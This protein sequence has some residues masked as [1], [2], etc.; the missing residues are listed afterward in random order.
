MGAMGANRLFRA[1]VSTFL[2]CALGMYAEAQAGEPV[3]VGLLAPMSGLSSHFGPILKNSAELAVEEINAAGGI[4]GRPVQLFVEDD[5][6]STA[7]AAEAAKN[8]LVKEQ[9]IALIGTIS[10][11][12]TNAVIPVATRAKRP[13]LYVIQG[14]YKG[15]NPYVFALGPTPYQ[16]MK[17][18]V[19]WMVKNLGKSFYLLGSDYVF[20]REMN[21]QIKRFLEPLGARVVG[22]EYLALGTKDFSTVLTRVEA[23]KPEVLFSVVVGSDA[24]A[25]L[26]Q[27]HEFGLQSKMKVNAYPG[28]NSAYYSGVKEIA[29]GKYTVG[30]YS[31]E[32]DNAVNKRFV[33]RYREKYKPAGPIVET[34]Y[35]TYTAVH[36]VKAAAEKAQSLDGDRLVKA[37]E[38]ITMDSPGGRITMDPKTHLATQYVYLFHVEPGGRYRV[39]ENFGPVE[40]PNIKCP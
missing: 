38:G 15:C 8:L 20:P 40:D 33:Q 7:P 26:K 28:I 29:E 6:F 27:A 24:F 17:F 30:V 13:F 21:A 9:A 1:V 5:K 36:L 39:A 10:S 16:Q 23:T 11:A 4:L 2:L 31:D 3:K 22:E 18:Y 32:I 19:P 37:L 34:A 25:L 14:E 35:A 12:T